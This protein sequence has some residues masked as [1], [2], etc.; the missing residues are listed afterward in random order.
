MESEKN[1][2]LVMETSDGE[3]LLKIEY[4]SGD[5]IPESL[6]GE[7]GFHVYHVRMLT[8]LLLRQLCKVSD[9]FDLSEEEISAISIASSLHDI[10]K[11]RIPKSILDFPGKL[12]PIEYDIVKKHSVFGEEIIAE[13]SGDIDPILIEHA[14]EIAR[15][16][17][18]R[19]DGTGYPDALKGNEIPISAQAVSLADAFDALTSARSYKQAF[20]QDVA[21][22][23]ISNGM[24]GVFN[25]LLTEC[26]Y[27]V[28]NNKVLIDI[29]ERFKEN[30]SVVLDPSVFIPKKVLFL[31]NTGYITKEFIEETFPSSSVMIIGE[32]KL[33]NSEK[34]KV[35]SRKR[36]PIDAILATYDFDFI[37]YF[38]NELTFGANTAS[39]A[40]ELRELLEGMTDLRHE[41]KLLYLSSLDAAFEKETDRAILARS[42]EK[43]CEYY[44]REHGIDTKVIRMPYLYSGTKGDDFLFSVFDRINKKGEIIFDE[45]KEARCYFLS[46]YDLSDLITRLSDNWKSGAGIL[47]INDEFNI[48]FSDISKKLSEIKSGIAVDYTG[49]KPPKVLKTNN[50]AL[51]NEYGW[52]SKISILADMEDQ[53]EKYLLSR[54]KK[55]LTLWDRIKELFSKYS[56]VFKII[57][58][59]LVFILTE[60]LIQTTDSAI[61]FSIVDFRMAFIVIMG[62]V[63]GLAFG[64]AA[65]GLSSISWF[66]AKVISGTK[67][68]TIFYE[69]TNWLAFVFFFFVGGLCGYIKLKSDD[70][71]GNYKEQN[72]LLEEKLIFTREIYTDTFNEKRD[73]K[74]QIIGSKDSFGKIFDI[75]RKLDTVD[76]R[77]L[78]L[79]IMDTFENILENKSISVYSVNEN[80]AFGR[81]EV[82]SR[83]IINDAAR[84]I[85]LN[86]VYK[87][88][89]EKLQGGGMWRNT[90]LAQGY[91]MYAAGVYRGE[92][93]VLLIFIWHAGLDQRSLYYA[94]LFKI[95]RDLVQM[96]LLRAYDYNQAVYQKQF[97]EGTHILNSETFG[98]NLE[99][100]RRMAERKVFS[101]VL[102]GVDKKEHSYAEIDEML[103]RR[104]RAND[105][106]GVTEEGE[107]RILLSQATKADLAFVLPRFEGLDIE[108]TVLN[109]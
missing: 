64:I 5:A 4:I 9:D 69:P 57:E 13:V 31:G 38:A 44:C 53:Y 25:P 78:Y 74:K 45:F 63:H 82:A 65:A 68:L 32:S 49:E 62:T 89:I 21:I 50:T 35:Y 22:E 71:I 56:L 98:K 46:M 55:G 12:S 88:V 6:N 43:L 85:A 40:E 41:A 8:E 109:N 96:S 14:K 48:S 17:H 30:N 76:P 28:V 105:I 84:S 42:K 27:Q 37:V 33:E 106:L 67:W 80:S 34:L 39:D 10:G 81:L 3:N 54:E 52:F 2:V 73:L 87:P 101:Y 97:I 95:L 36:P 29:R 108:I 47:N 92:R 83:D 15:S 104:I 16:H 102:L 103:S 60:I 51:R 75:T 24:C 93:L 90:E 99:N 77:E 7:S 100:F 79:K 86:D 26:L 59:F 20:S 23:M 66:A 70:K 58:L 1:P 61:F 18:E 72:E 94:N 91:P 107:I 19:Y 11:S